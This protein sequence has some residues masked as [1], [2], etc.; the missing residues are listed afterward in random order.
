VTYR[1]VAASADDP[2]VLRLPATSELPPWL[3]GWVD[4]DRFTLLNVASPFEVRFYA[5]PLRGTPAPRP[6][7]PSGRQVRIAAG[8]PTGGVEQSF[9]WGRTGG[10]TGSATDRAVAVYVGGRLAGLGGVRDGRFA[11]TFALRPHVPVRVFGIAHG[12]ATE[13]AYATGYAW[14]H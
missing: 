14:A 9:D 11:V 8:T 1:F 12:R 4:Y 7:A 10:V 6:T 3:G 5:V 13:L 2:L